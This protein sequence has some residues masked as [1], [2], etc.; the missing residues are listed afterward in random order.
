MNSTLLSRYLTVLFS[1]IMIS[2]SAQESTNTSG[3]NATGIGGN[4]SYSIGQVIYTTNT[5]TNGSVAQGVQHA[6]EIYSIGVN[7]TTL[8]IS[9]NIFPNPTAENLTL[10][11]SH[12]TNEQVSYQLFDAQGKLISTGQI[13]SQQT[14][15]NMGDLPSACYFIHVVNNENK[16]AQSFK[17][18]KR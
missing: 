6:Y 17:I 4:V 11:I 12:Y 2:L 18:I 5:G 3:G 10:E 13:T 16:K 8:H 1:G 7:E 15:I 14:Q 9:V